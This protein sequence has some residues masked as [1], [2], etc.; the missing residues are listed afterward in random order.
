MILTKAITD[1]EQGALASSPS[2]SAEQFK[3]YIGSRERKKS[4]N[5]LGKEGTQ[6][7]TGDSYGPNGKQGFIRGFTGVSTRSVMVSL[8]LWEKERLR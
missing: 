8:D 1:K 4:E 2:P 3:S 7:A 6:E 5:R